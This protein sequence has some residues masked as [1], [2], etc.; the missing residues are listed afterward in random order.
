MPDHEFKKYASRGAYHWEALSRSVKRHNPYLAG[1]YKIVVEFLVKAGLKGKSVLDIGCGDGAL[2]FLMAGGGWHVTGLDYS[3]TGLGLARKK[4][5]ERGVKASF[6]RGDSCNI[7]VKGDSLDAVVAADI[8]EHLREPEKMLSDIRRVLKSGGAA[9][10]TTPVKLTE[11][12][13]DPEHVREFTEEEFRD[14]LKKYFVD[15]EVRLS[16][17]KAA[18]VKY[19]KAYRILGMFG[20]VRPYRYLYNAMSSY[21]GN[22][23]FLAPAL[24]GVYTQMSA[25]ARKK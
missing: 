16:H 6:F 10:I 4:F 2:S 22:N 23:P 1:R 7:P 13:E 14:I 11:T 20:R 21:T 25:L 9:V 15:V 24:G 18:V 19:G 12:P 17:P 8:I 5:R 3:G